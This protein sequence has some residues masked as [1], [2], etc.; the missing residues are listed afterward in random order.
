M[1]RA[2]ELV[3]R[4]ALRSRFV[5][6]LA[7]ALL[8]LAVVGVARLMAGPGRTADLQ[9]GP[10]QR[11]LVSTT[12]IDGDDGMHGPLTPASPTPIPGAPRPEEVARA[13]AVA[14]ADHRGVSP[15][16]WRQSLQPL[17]TADLMEKLAD[18]DP[19]VVPA[20]R[21]TGEPTLTALTPNVVE[22]ELAV[23]TGTL[24][25]RLV[26]TADRWLVDGVDW[27]RS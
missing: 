1:R 19:I 21:V 26:A 5:L 10:P 4:G 20:N 2:I 7:L 18:V 15:E 3:V 6:A 16:Q 24:R 27:E 14:W 22:V 23:N 9:I 8:I 17:S 12:E 13:F 11:P 25:L